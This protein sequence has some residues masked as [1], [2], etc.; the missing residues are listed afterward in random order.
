MERA[1]EW[2]CEWEST[3]RYTIHFEDIELWRAWP[4]YCFAIFWQRAYYVNEL[5]CDFVSWKG[6]VSIR[7]VNVDDP[8]STD[9]SRKCW[10]F[11][12][13]SHKMKS[14]PAAHM[15]TNECA[16][17]VCFRSVGPLSILVRENGHV[18]PLRKYGACCEWWMG[19]CDLVVM[20]EANRS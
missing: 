15:F 19:E 4:S 16:C 18:F 8:F 1:L 13:N 2:W 14:K 5:R 10:K 20:R 17:G 9:R 11:A 6:R 3:C 12:T 7:F